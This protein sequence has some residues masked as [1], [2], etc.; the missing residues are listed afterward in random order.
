MFTVCLLCQQHGDA[1]SEV[2]AGLGDFTGLILGR[3]VF[4]VG[5]DEDAP[6]KGLRACGPITITG[7]WDDGR[8]T[9]YVCQERFLPGPEGRAVLVDRASDARLGL[10]CPACGVALLTPE[11]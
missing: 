10:V 1:F 8:E 7:V 9:C 5:C 3:P 2:C 6:P 4:S 11:E